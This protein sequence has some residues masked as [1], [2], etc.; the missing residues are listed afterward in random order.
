M[1]MLAVPDR[2]LRRFNTVFKNR[3]NVPMQRGEEL[4]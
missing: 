3:A 1:T 4:E 2:I